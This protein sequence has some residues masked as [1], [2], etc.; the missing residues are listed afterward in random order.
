MKVGLLFLFIFSQF[1]F[2]QRGFV[3]PDKQ[4]KI[5]IPFETIN[6]LVFITVEINQVPLTFLL[7]T[8][9]AQTIL[10]SL[11]DKE[12]DLHNK[13]K[14]KFSGLG[15][16]K[17]V[18]G[19][20][21]R[22]N[23]VKITDQ[24]IDHQHTIYIVLDENFNFS[25]FI[26]I[27]V[28][29]IIGYDFFKNHPVE[30]NYL[31]KKITIYN[32]ENYYK[33][34]TKKFTE[35][36]LQIENSKPYLIGNVDLTTQKSSSKVLIDTGNSD[37]LW[38]FPNKMEGFFHDHPNIEDFLGRG[39]NGDIHGKR[40]RIHNF[41]I[42]D[43]QVKEPIT[44]VPDAASI[45]QLQFEKDREGS[46]GSEIMRRFTTIYDYKNSKRLLKKNKNYDEP[47]HLNMSGLDFKHIGMKWE[48][49]YLKLIE[50]KTDG[51]QNKESVASL[52]NFQYKFVLKPVFA[53]AGIRENSPA[54]LAGIKK[55]DVVETINGRSI[56]DLKLEDIN[57]MMRKD[58]GRIIRIE[59]TRKE[60]PMN[61]SFILTDPI[62]YKE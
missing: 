4:K 18:E 3:I 54:Y 60:V 10:F 23:I 45:K 43:F 33:R 41:Y 11:G 6:N 44:S 26:G 50:P 42:G 8:G 24:Y 21:S 31:S 14:M 40:T 38:L 20:R 17:E 9:V 7:D 34:K 22:N 5:T 57:Q 25:T 46:I 49:E 58:E 32:D 28:H 39:F 19:I 48:K 35:L 61:F 36:P 12:I 47:F 37:A 15:G 52:V 59:I 30:I 27:P 29:G 51:A 56:S 16:D 13:E 55:N 62:P 1:C 2:A 53:I